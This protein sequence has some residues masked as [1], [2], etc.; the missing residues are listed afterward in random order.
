MDA[1]LLNWF[2]FEQVKPSI[3]HFETAHMTS[4]DHLEVRGRLE[5]YGYFVREADSELDD[6]AV[7]I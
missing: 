1:Q 2:L 7:I 5:G 3:L 6:I 4:A